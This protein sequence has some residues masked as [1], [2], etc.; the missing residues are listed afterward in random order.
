MN[1]DHKFMSLALAEANKGYGKVSPNPLVGAVVVKNENI[2]SVGHHER[3]GSEHAEVMALENLSK[4]EI[5]ESTLYVT[6]E[7][8]CH[9]NKK[10][11]PCTKLL[12]TKKPKRIVICNI[13]PNPE[14]SG[15]GIQILRD[16]GIEVDCGVLE[17]EGNKLNKIFFKFMN[18]GKPWVHLKYAQ[19]MDGKISAVTGDSK[20]ISDED[21]RKEVHQLRLGY[22]AIL[23]GKNTVI[24]DDPSLTIRYGF[25]SEKSCPYRTIVGD[26]TGLDINSKIFN[27]KFV[28]KTII[29]CIDNEANRKLAPLFICKGVDIA[30]MHDTEKIISTERILKVLGKRNISSL[31]VEGGSKII[32]QFIVEK[33]I[34][35]VTSYIAP[36]IIG[37]G[38]D[39]FA[40]GGIEKM[41]EAINFKN[42]LYR[43]LNNQVVMDAEGV[44]S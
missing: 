17:E 24:S 2:I 44:M 12:L 28:K 3:Y 16:A 14:V 39:F 36:K 35:Q 40:H 10:T 23:I 25:E 18:T 29:I 20:W 19:T 34:D 30:F 4:E 37:S 41:S 42:P 11:P 43:I 7:P 5:A 15:K 26:L 1:L 31:I 8:C 38:K 9:T 33:N 32:S 13:D 6:L 27:D 21:A 22:D